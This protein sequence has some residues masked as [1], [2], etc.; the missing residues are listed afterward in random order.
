MIRNK[1]SWIDYSILLSYIVWIG[2][3]EKARFLGGGGGGEER[4]DV[5]FLGE[6]KIFEGGQARFLGQAKQDF[7]GGGKGKISSRGGKD[8]W[9]ERVRFLRGKNGNISFWGRKATFQGG[10]HFLERGEGCKPVFSLQC[11]RPHVLSPL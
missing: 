3:W 6:G 8:F 1:G 10:R 5:R 11:K 9:G 7:W 2:P 4:V